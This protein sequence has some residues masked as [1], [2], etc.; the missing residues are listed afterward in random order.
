MTTVL[1]D[2]A[3]TETDAFLEKLWDNSCNFVYK[4]DI[5]PRGYGYL[6]FVEDFVDDAQTDLIKK[7]PLNR[8]TKRILDLQG[9]LEDL[10]E[11]TKDNENLGGLLGVLSKYIH[12]GNLIY[13]ESEDA[14]PLVLKDMGAFY[15]NTAG[16]T[17]LFRSIKYKPVG[18]PMDHFMGWHM[19]IINGPG[20]SYPE[21]ELS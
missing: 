8:I 6:S 11:S 14:K 10:V 19:D 17:G 5:V 15:K 2:N 16:E 18:N 3:T 20:L 4:N 1:L 13:Y 21:D 9:K 12:M 7:V